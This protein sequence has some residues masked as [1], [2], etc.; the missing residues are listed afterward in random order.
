M[1]DSAS[2]DWTILGSAT[3]RS[4]PANFARMVDVLAPDAAQTRLALGDYVIEHEACNARKEEIR[5]ESQMRGYHFGLFSG[6]RWWDSIRGKDVTLPFEAVFNPTVDGKVV[7]NRSSSRKRNDG[8][9]SFLWVTPAAVQSAEGKTQSGHA[10]AAQ[11]TLKEA[12]LA[13]CWQCNPDETFIANPL[14]ADLAILDNAPPLRDS[15]L[16]VGKTLETYLD[17]LCQPLSILWHVEYDTGG[18]LWVKNK[19]T[20]RFFVK[21]IGPQKKV[22]FQAPGSVLD[23]SQANCN[24]YRVTR[25]IGDSVNS[26]HVLGSRIE[27]ECTFPL[28]RGWSA[29]DDSLTAAE[30]DRSDR[31]SKFKD[32]P[33]VWRLWVANE[34]GD[35]TDVR[36]GMDV[37]DLEAEFDIGSTGSGNNYIPHR[38]N[39]TDPISFK[40]QAKHEK[41]SLCVE[42]SDDGGATWQEISDAFG[43]VSLFEDQI[44]IYFEDD[45]PPKA[46]I[47]AGGQ[48]KLR[49]TGVI[50]GDNRLTGFASRPSFATN[51][52]DVPL[53][54]DQMQKFQYRKKLTTG[55]Y[56]SVFP[57]PADEIDDSAAIVDYAINLRN[58]SVA[59]EVSCEVKLP[60]IHL[61]YRLGDTLS[62][63]NGRAIDLNGYPAGSGLSLLP[64]VVKRVFQFSPSPMTTLT[65]DRGVATIVGQAN[66][67]NRLVPLEVQ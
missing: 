66:G 16:P 7:G 26:V 12:V 64:Q 52:R 4:Q 59:A 11:W 33:D 35:Y 1:I 61:S 8:N 38:R 45:Q 31:S 55:P 36:V 18:T 6:Q 34:A 23:L 10:D 65:L 47:A 30:L 44:A 17:S 62:E 22:Y 50:T 39:I 14:R 41:Q 32:K 53:V 63:I 13:M 42:Y 49:L 25:R 15:R 60:G 5:G 51:G 20:I 3:N 57:G 21:G 24:D 43:E 2:F 54:I 28:Q 29:A 46:L 56:A 19:P 9:D 40:S 67:P 48:A 58:K 27:L 37:P